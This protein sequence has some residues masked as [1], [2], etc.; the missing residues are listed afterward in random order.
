MADARTNSPTSDVLSD[1]MDS[2]SMRDKSLLKR[3]TSKHHNNNL[4][5]GYVPVHEQYIEKTGLRGRKT[6]AFWTLVSLL[7]ILAV[8]NLIL[9]MTILGVLK[10]GKGMQSLELV[11]E[12]YAIKFFGNTDLG[13][14]YKRDGK[15]EGF[16]DEPVDITS[17]NGSI[18]IN[19]L[20]RTGRSI[21]KMKLI[22][23]G[24]YINSVDSFEVKNTNGDTIFNTN[25][26]SFQFKKSVKAITTKMVQTNRIVSPI[27]EH[28]NIES[29]NTT[30]RGS[31][32]TN[33]EG[34]EVI[35]RVDQNI[36]LK[37]INGSI[38]L[39]GEKGAFIEK[40]PIVSQYGN[41]TAQ[42][43][44][45]VCMPQGKLFRVLAPLDSKSPVYCNHIKLSPKH[46]PCI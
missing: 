10:L 43:K 37:S 33:I 39:S 11:P 28:L 30:L 19:F 3:S 24:I 45:C 26:P 34:R 42:Y 46:N 36:Y 4:K 22:R 5:A 35:W 7:F 31:E 23:K 6:F 8:G 41:V 2:L 1:G 38:I 32:G 18:V 21:E 17:E 40:I 27:D 16:H 29:K 13:H 15:I 44:I 25:N 9:T 20:S 12:E 14:L